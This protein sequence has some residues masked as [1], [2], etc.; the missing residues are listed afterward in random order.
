M[1]RGS[2]QSGPIRL[3]VIG[4][5]RM[6]ELHSRVA[7]QNRGIAL[8]GVYDPNRARAERIA[9][10]HEVTAF[11]ELERLLSSVDA[12]II[13]APTSLHE[14]LALIALRRG[15]HTLIEKPIAATVDEAR[16]I[17]DAV[18]S[19]GVVCLVGHTERYNMTFRELL[20]VLE[21]TRPL[22]M[23]IRRLNP[24]APRITD[25][26]VTLDLLIHDADLA[27]TVAGEQPTSI[28]ASGLRVL[29]ERLDYVNAIL[30]FGSGMV[31]SLTAS[32]VTEDKIRRIEVTTK[33]RYIVA[34]LLTRTLTIHRRAVSEWAVA[35]PDVKFTLESITHQVQV[36][37]VEPLAVE[38][39]DFV[40]AIREGRRAMVDASDGADALEVTIAVRRLAEAH[41]PVLLGEGASRPTDEAAGAR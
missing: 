3:G 31:A 37:N 19:A 35:G 13:A 34:D 20:I 24:L 27:L 38:Q 14:E 16:R 7:S 25:A 1:N 30:T 10:A 36:P 2:A 32:R 26:D 11:P 17:Q 33:D 18:A 4:A 21:R 22:A 39:Q 6:G 29:S 12:V 28:F 23:S 9:R 40:D 41:A 15:L 5:G 8:A